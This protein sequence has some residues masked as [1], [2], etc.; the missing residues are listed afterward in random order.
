M[1]RSISRIGLPMLALAMGGLGFYH[2]NRESQAL[3]PTAPPE[4]PARS[5]FV[6]SV[7]ASGLVEARTENIAIGAALSGLVLEVYVPSDRVGTHVVAGQPLFRVDDRHLKAQ[8]RVAEAQLAMAES[9]LAKLQQQPR[10]E[11]LPPSLAK[12]KAA[13]ANV[14]STEDQYDRAKR[15]VERETLAREEYV[16]RKWAYDAAVHELA[17]A[18]ADYDLLKAG[19]WKPDIDVAKAAVAEARSQI[20]QART[21]IARA[22]V[23]A[24]VDG[25]VLQV[26]VRAGERVSDRDTK[27]LM[28]LGD[29]GTYHVRVDIDERDIARFRPGAPAKAFPRGATDHDVTMQFVRVE[30]YVV[31]KKSLT[32]DNTER[33]DTR[34]LQVLYAVDRADRP[35]YVGQ[36]LDVFIDVSAMGTDSVSDSNAAMQRK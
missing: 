2:V 23:V 15:L 13:A 17:R 27:A 32:G 5:P 28:V 30:P 33:V 11:E 4:Y 29:I 24:P 8:L 22:T 9:R 1:N 35:V 18:Q 10:P 3:P 21:E 12:V 36:Q 7:A 6:N 20:E 31:P 16:T 25:V 19:A 34:V 14:A 26:N